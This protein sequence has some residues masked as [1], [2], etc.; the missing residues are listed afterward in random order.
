MKI[1]YRI[2]FINDLDVDKL[3]EHSD[4]ELLGMLKALAEETLNLEVSNLRNTERLEEAVAT[5]VK[6]HNIHLR[7]TSAVDIWHP[8]P[9][10]PDDMS[11]KEGQQ[12][13]LPDEDKWYENRQ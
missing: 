5:M 6:L 9:T 4:E 7:K 2:K 3:E 11:L 13:T 8:K 12:P 10:P 1:G